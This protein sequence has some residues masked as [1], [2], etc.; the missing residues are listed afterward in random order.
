MS[1]SRLAMCI[2]G[3]PRTWR[4][5]FESQFAFFKAF[6]VDVYLHCWDDV[7]ADE[8]EELKAAY[9]PV[10]MI[11]ESRP[12]T[13]ELK[14]MMALQYPDNPPLGVFDMAHGLSRA[15]QAALESEQTYDLVA[16]VR[17]DSLFDGPY[18]QTREPHCWL[19]LYR[20]VNGSGINDQ[21]MIGTP[22]GMQIV[23][24]WSD[25]LRSPPWPVDGPTFRPEQMFLRYLMVTQVPYCEEDFRQKLLRPLMIGREFDHIR[26]DHLFQVRKKCAWAEEAET[27]DDHNLKGARFFTGFKPLLEIEPLVQPLLDTLSP[28][29][30]Q[31]LYMGTWSERYQMTDK[32]IHMMFPSLAMM[33]ITDTDLRTA[34]LVVT[35]LVQRMDKSRDQDMFATALMA[36]SAAPDDNNMARDWVLAFPE[37]ARTLG[38]NLDLLTLGP[39]LGYMLQELTKTPAP[40]LMTAASA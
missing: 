14:S 2:S 21:F 13:A 20:W 29:D 32:V 6:D 33:D 3:E 25:W 11:I 28:E 36:I 24:N 40:P 22:E 38:S 35:L 23:A 16:R 27:S 8:I 26:E 1:T 34:R 39:C 17:Y 5:C 9:H 15:L 4:H 10:D 7:P 18:P 19:H 12:D 30:T 31:A 37:Q